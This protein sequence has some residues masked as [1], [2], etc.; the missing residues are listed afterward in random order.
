[1]LP[2]RTFHEN[3]FD[4]TILERRPILVA[5]MLKDPELSE[6]H[7]GRIWVESEVCRGSVF[8]FEVPLRLEQGVE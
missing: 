5:D 1:M 4:G 3:P 8:S 7:G 6:M 2:P